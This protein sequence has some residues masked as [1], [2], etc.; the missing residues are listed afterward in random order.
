VSS[1]P[2]F[3]NCPSL[4]LFFRSQGSGYMGARGTDTWT[5]P[6]ALR[7]DA[8]RRR[9]RVLLDACLRRHDR[10]AAGAS[11]GMTEPL[12][13]C[14]GMTGGPRVQSRC[15]SGHTP[16][17]VKLSILPK[18]PKFGF[19]L[20]GSGVRGMGRWLGVG[21]RAGEAAGRMGGK[22]NPGAGCFPGAPGLSMTSVYPAWRAHARQDRRMLSIT[23]GGAITGMQ[24][25]QAS[26]SVCADY[27]RFGDGF[28]GNS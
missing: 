28:Q 6:F 2:S 23:S 27:T 22:S 4:G 14:L 17:D 21:L 19:V 13:V 8:S 25:H 12:P 5:R 24:V 10:V 16:G 20:Q 9:P 15:T 7:R 18:L 3:L 11:A 1:C 26:P